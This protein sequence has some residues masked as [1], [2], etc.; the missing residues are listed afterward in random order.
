M[1]GNGTSA[2]YKH[3][4]M[5]P[6][7]N[8]IITALTGIRD[9][10]RLLRTL[11]EDPESG[12][13]TNGVMNDFA[14]AALAVSMSTAGSNTASAVASA[15]QN[16]TVA[17]NGSGVAEPTGDSASNLAAER[18]EILGALGVQE[19]PKDLKTLIRI[20]GLY[21]WEAA[22]TAGPD[23]G[24]RG[25]TTQVTPFAQGELLG[26]D[27]EVTGQITAG[28]PAGPP[29]AIP[30]PSKPRKRWPFARPPGETASQIASPTADL[31]DPATGDVLPKSVEDQQA[32]A[33]SADTPPPA[34]TYGIP[35]DFPD[36]TLAPGE[37]VSST[38]K[39]ADGNY[40]SYV[41]TSTGVDEDGYSFTSTRRI[42][43]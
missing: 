16:K 31:V 15:I 1:A 42:E 30:N 34:A 17:L 2:P 41:V 39:D 22:G 3:I 29:N 4:D 7:Y 6:E 20:S 13:V 21:Y 14:R 33:K 18:A 8:R 23:D 24:L 10:I 28:E 19:D 32:E 9:D 37:Q 40:V 25:S 38:A 35:S 11:Q 26:F 27:N 43:L 36:I 5:T 12:I